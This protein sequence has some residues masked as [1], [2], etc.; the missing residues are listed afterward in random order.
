LDSFNLAP[1]N[2][3]G[4]GLV[5]CSDSELFFDILY[6]FENRRERGISLTQGLYLHRTAQ[7]KTN[8]HTVIG[9]RTHDFSD[10]GVRLRPRGHWAQQF[11][12]YL[13]NFLFNDDDSISGM[14]DG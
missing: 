3:K 5:T 7:H 2:W 13:F 12:L 9:I 8:V 6:H 11:V 4:L 1:F 14:S 10:Q